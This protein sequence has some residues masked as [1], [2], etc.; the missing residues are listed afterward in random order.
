MFSGKP[1]RQSKSIDHLRLMHTEKTWLGRRAETSIG[2]GTDETTIFDIY[3]VLDIYV[4]L[5][6]TYMIFD[7]AYSVNTRLVNYCSPRLL[8]LERDAAET[9]CG[10]TPPRRI[11]VHWRY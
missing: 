7:S 9:S 6:I 3:V 10:A 1:S 8:I 5:S 2:R 4:I 11:S